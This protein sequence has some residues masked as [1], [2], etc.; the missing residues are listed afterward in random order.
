M[1]WIH[2][3]QRDAKR[4]VS[5]PALV[6]AVLVFA[7]SFLLATGVATAAPQSGQRFTG[8]FQV[9][10]ADQA[11]QRYDVVILNEWNSSQITQL[12]AANPAVKV[13]LYKNTYFLRSDDNSSTVGGF[14]TGE[15]INST[16]PDWFLKDASG[17]RIV[18]QYYAGIDF[19]AMDW[20]NQAWRDY[21]VTQA[22][23]RVKALGFDGLFLDDLYTKPWGEIDRPLLN[24]TSEAQLQAAVRG[25]LANTYTKTKAADSNLL[26]IGNLVDHLWFPGL[27]ADWLKVSDGLMDEQFVHAGES[28]TTGYKSIE[29]WWKLQLDEVTVAEQMGKRALFISHGAATD[30]ETML[31]GYGSY[32]LA[33]GGN[34][35]YYH[36][37]GGSLN[38]ATWF[39][40][41]ARDLGAAQGSYTV[42]SDGLYSRNFAGG[43][44]IVNPSKS[45]TRTVSVSGYVNEGGTAVN[46]VTLAPHRAVFLFKAATTT[47]TVPPTTTT[48]AAPTTTTTA[49]PT[50]TT[51]KIPPT[52]TTTAPT[53]TT[54][55]IP[56]TT[57]TTTVPTVTTTPPTPTMTTTVAPKTAVTPQALPVIQFVSPEDGALIKGRVTVQVKATSTVG[58]LK[59][60]LLVDGKAVG[61]DKSSPYGFIWNADKVSEGDHTLLAVAYDR[62]GN[63]AG[64]AITVK[65]ITSNTAKVRAAIAASS[66]RFSGT[67]AFLNSTGVLYVE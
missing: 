40:L 32:M 55:N 45:S 47:T 33:A 26:V 2:K 48:T 64:T 36:E 20:G 25:F 8:L 56:P 6:S 38:T 43:K 30:Y 67:S 54:T 60:E 34:G 11:A 41:W 9:G 50:T 46:S 29:D 57:T 18:F 35:R 17:N 13:L 23:G 62:V 19:Y 7:F 22:V 27:F 63:V 24:Y 12:K 14:K 61:S 65:S 16:H 5:L 53:T 37:L 42:G 39:D 51:T 49:A 28:T 4:L 59:V 15:N 44:V 52:T 3:P 58:I 1:A 21:W 66:Y 10:S 31:F